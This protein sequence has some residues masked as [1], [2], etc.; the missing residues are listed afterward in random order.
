M[1][2][3]YL[4]NF[5]NSNSIVRIETKR[6]PLFGSSGS[7]IGSGFFVKP[8]M[9]VTNIHAIT[10]RGSVLVK[11]TD[12]KTT[13]K[14]EG[15]TAFDVKNDIVVLKV[16]GEGTPLPLGDSSVVQNGEHISVVGFP[17]G[18]YKVAEG[19]VQSRRESN[20][21]IQMK[22]DISAGNSGS[23]T[24]NDKRQVIGIVV[25]SSSN[26]SCSWAI[27]S[28]ALKALLDRLEPAEPLVKWRKRKIIRS[29]TKYFQGKRNSW[30]ERYRKAIV[31]FDKAIKLNPKLID[32]YEERGI[33][34]SELGD[35]EG[36][37]VDFDKVITL[38]PK[39]AHA[40]KNRGLAKSKFGDFEG[41]IA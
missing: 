21:L 31:D 2:T 20:K 12:G 8:D 11:S 1:S 29:Y 32:V 14:V 37:I 34:K 27:P 18:K 13:W 6:I 41:A 3:E 4:P 9:I 24:L 36:A 40:Y 10:D 7:S 19:V 26:Y 22:A 17:Y 15:V 5:K 28:N 35:F 33:A 30:K 23:P 38:N 16:A 25:E 39:D